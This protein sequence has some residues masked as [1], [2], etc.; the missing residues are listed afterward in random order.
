MLLTPLVEAGVNAV[1]DSIRTYKRKRELR[2][3]AQTVDAPIDDLGDAYGQAC[4]PAAVASAG[5][6]ARFAVPVSGS[7]CPDGLS[8]PP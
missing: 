4:G 5:E 3:T 1:R 2:Q 8:R 7:D 6:L